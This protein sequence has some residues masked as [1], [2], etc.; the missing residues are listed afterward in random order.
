M[1]QALV[2]GNAALA[3]LGGIGEELGGDRGYGYAAAVEILSAALTDG[4]FMKALPGQAPDG[5]R[6]MYHFGH[7]F[8]S[9][10][11]D[12]FGDRE[13]FKRITGESLQQGHLAVRDALRLPY[14]FVFEDWES[15]SGSFVRLFFR[16]W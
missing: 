10:D 3:P 5:T 8:F 16:P 1:L 7:F 2:D 11:P 13:E 6:Q 9:V 15:S 12:A 4:Q 14:H